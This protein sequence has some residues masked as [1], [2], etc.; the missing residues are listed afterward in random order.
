M[1]LR[2][3]LTLALFC[4]WTYEKIDTRPKITILAIA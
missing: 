1:A 3:I 2:L 4:L